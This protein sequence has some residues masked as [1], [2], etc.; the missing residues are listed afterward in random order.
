[1]TAI[2]LPSL[3]VTVAVPAIRVT[4]PAMPTTSAMLWIWRDQPAELPQ[5]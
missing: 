5:R 1:M 2:R 3:P 4:A